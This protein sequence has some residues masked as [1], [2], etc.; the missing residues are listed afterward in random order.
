MGSKELP[1]EVRGC[2]RT[3]KYNNL[4]ILTRAGSSGKVQ[5]NAGSQVDMAFIF[6]CGDRFY[7]P[8]QRRMA[9]S[10]PASNFNDITSKNKCPLCLFNSAFGP[11]LTWLPSGPDSSRWW[12]EVEVSAMVDWP[13]PSSRK[14][15]H[16]LGFANF[17][18]HFIHDCTTVVA[19]L[20]SLTSPWRLFQ[21]SDK[22]DVTFSRLK[23]AFT[24]APIL[25]NLDP[26]CQFMVAMDA[27]VLAVGTALFIRESIPA[28]SS[29][30][31][32]LLWS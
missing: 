31:G 22:T 29:I 16:F 17:C 2:S 24:F 26:S 9:L 10:I 11:N 14:Q 5:R 27:S 4:T 21:M 30:D 13:D 20:T 1:D 25:S 15:F 32:F 6:L 12:A 8:S 19:P 18:R 23:S 28:P 3:G 7:S